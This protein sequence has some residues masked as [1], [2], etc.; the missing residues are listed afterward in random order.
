MIKNIC[1]CISDYKNKGFLT[2][3]IDTFQNVLYKNEFS[4]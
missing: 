3:D 4:D 1:C 2:Q